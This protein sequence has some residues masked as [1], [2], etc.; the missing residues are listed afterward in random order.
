MAGASAGASLIEGLQQQQNAQAVADFNAR[1]FGAVRD[2]ALATFQQA[3]AQ[4]RQRTI[5]ERTQVAEEL[6]TITSDALRVRGRIRTS[7]AAGNVSGTSIEEARLD[8]ERAAGSQRRQVEITQRFREAQAEQEI[9]ALLLQTEGR[10]AA[11]LP[12]PINVPSDF[13]VVLGG[14][15]GGLNGFAMGQGLI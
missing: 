4:V 8:T 15:T 9:R 12:P 2:N 6:A 14:L 1:R 3:G 7:G 11:A 13:N 5:Q 10:I